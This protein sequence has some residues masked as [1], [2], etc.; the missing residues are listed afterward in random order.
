MNAN[1]FNAAGVSTLNGETK[2]R[3]ANGCDARIKRL[4][5]FG[6]TDINMVELSSPMTK[7]EAAAALYVMP[8]FAAA[9]PY[10]AAVLEAAGVELPV[11]PVVAAKPAKA[12]S[13]TK[14]AIRKRAARAAKMAEMA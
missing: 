8:E 4:A 7:V 14:D 5:M 10:L 3:V 11:A 2:L 9:K 1:T 13:M 12:L 6:H